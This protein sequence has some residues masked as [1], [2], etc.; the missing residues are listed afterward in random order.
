VNEQGI[1]PYG[2]YT[3]NKVAAIGNIYKD[4]NLRLN[5]TASAS[6]WKSVDMVLKWCVVADSSRCVKQKQETPYF[7]QRTAAVVGQLWVMV[8]VRRQ[9]HDK[10]HQHWHK[11]M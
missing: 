9:P 6:S 4:G 8:S 3:K 5:T 7:Q 10:M 1:K 11:V 2:C